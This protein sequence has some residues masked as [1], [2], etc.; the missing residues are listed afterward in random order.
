MQRG[1]A[2]NLDSAKVISFSYH[3]SDPSFL[4]FFSPGQIGQLK[5]TPDWPRDYGAGHGHEKSQKTGVRK[6]KWK[7]LLKRPLRPFH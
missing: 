3:F 2:Y 5:A 4:T 7:S 1:L 6:M